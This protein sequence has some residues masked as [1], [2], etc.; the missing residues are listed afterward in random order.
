MHANDNHASPG[1]TI[2]EVSYCRGMLDGKPCLVKYNATTDET[3]VVA[4]KS[5]FYANAMAALEVLD[6]ATVKIP[7]A[8]KRTI[9]HPG[10]I[11]AGR[12]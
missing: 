9:I 10:R 6:A 3:T 12:H 7:L 5:R 2:T 11:E 4:P 8:R 1:L